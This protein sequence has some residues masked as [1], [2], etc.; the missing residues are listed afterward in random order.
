VPSPGAQA[1]DTPATA[2]A[3]RAMIPHL[4][5]RVVVQDRL[6]E[7]R[8]IGGADASAMRLDP[9]RTVHAALVALDVPGLR[10]LG[11]AGAVRRGGLPY[12]PGLLGFREAPA[13]AEAWARLEPKPDLLM[14]DGHGQ[15]HPRGLGI[16]SLLG[17]LL[18][19]PTIGVAKSLLVGQVE[20]DLPAAPGAVAPVV[21]KG[22]QIGIALRTRR[23]ANPVYVSAGHRVGL[24]TALD[25]VRRTLRGY[26]L[27]E[28][29]R[30]A[31]AAAAEVRRAGA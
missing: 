28:P 25:W 17:V 20:G 29:T 3:A 12:I 14:V 13:L 9:D 31:H 16:A 6:G 30:A 11:S 4:A 5:A 10:I 23:A 27:P 1:L 24:P 21:W 8:V 15:A 22:T 7:V 26:R 2:A 18:D 19:A